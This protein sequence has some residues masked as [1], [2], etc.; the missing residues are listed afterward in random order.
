MTLAGL[1]AIVEPALCPLS[2]RQRS[3]CIPAARLAFA[4]PTVLAGTPRPLVTLP[5]KPL[6]SQP[7]RRILV[8]HD[9]LHGGE[10]L[11]DGIVGAFCYRVGVYQPQLP[12]NGY[13]GVYIYFVAE[14]ARA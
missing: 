9:V 6:H 4:L 13:F 14:F 2:R 10:A 5:Q 11:L 1:T 3:S 12:I 7:L 8:D